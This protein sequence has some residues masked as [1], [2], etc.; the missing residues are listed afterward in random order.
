M[1]GIIKQLL[2]YPM[3]I[4]NSIFLYFYYKLSKKGRYEV[5]EVLNQSTQRVVILAPHVDDESI[6]AGAA[7]LKHARSGDEITCVYIT[8]GSACNTDFSRDTIIAARK[9]E[10]EKV[11]E[12]IGL[13]EIIFLDEQDGNVS[14]NQNLVNKIYEILYRINPDVIYVPFIIDGHTDHVETTKSLLYAL[15][16]YNTDFSNIYLYEVNCPIIPNIINIINILDVELFKQKKELLNQFK[17]QSVMDFDVFLLL[18]RMER[19][20]NGKCYGAEVFIKTDVKKLKAICKELEN[21]GFKPE[22]FRQLSS[23]Y[24]LLISLIKSY[25]LK[26]KYSKIVHKI[27]NQGQK[28]VASLGKNY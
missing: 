21:E 15:E 16:Q 3:K 4:A 8:D 25:S 19:L 22:Q 1:K 5:K 13:K 10:A 6:G 12:F 23:R 28:G 20:L 18:N 14:S 27:I 24:N 26:K 9:E 17:S 2:N 11:K 7:L